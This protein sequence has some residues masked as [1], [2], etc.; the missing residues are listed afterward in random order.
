MEPTPPVTGGSS[1]A[2]DVVLRLRER[3][4]AEAGLDA[5]ILFGS[6]ARGQLS[7]WSDVDVAVLRSARGAAPTDLTALAVALEVEC[8]RDIQMLDLERAPADI[9]RTVLDEGSVLFARTPGRLEDLAE[10]TMLEYWD[11]AWMRDDLRR[12]HDAF[13]AGGRSGR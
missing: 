3:L 2:P 9:R 8:G 6:A 10:A 12:A 4:E 5:A 1:L 7:P 13:F 11:M